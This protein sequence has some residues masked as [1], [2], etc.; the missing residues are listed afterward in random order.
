MPAR[1][2]H[3]RLGPR[4][5][6]IPRLE[7]SA[8]DFGGGKSQAF[9]EQRGLIARLPRFFV[10]SAHRR[11]FAKRRQRTRQL[12]CVSEGLRIVE[13]IACVTRLLG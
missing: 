6:R 2:L 10:P 5:S 8:L 4:R 11:A 1:E 3:E 12:A 7:I 9:N 13:R